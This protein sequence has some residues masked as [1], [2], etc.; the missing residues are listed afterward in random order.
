MTLPEDPLQVFWDHILSRDPEQ[1]RAAFAAL[2][3]AT[4]KTVTVHLER[5]IHEP[6]WHPEQRL[7]AQ[8]ALEAIS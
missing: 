3:L 4:Q 1:I 5:M 8:I 7:S 2:D 6:D